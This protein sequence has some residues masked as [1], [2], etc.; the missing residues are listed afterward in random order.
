MQTPTWNRELFTQTF[1]R[2]TAETDLT[3]T[4][5][6]KL[7]GTS[8]A[9]MSRWANG[10][11]KPNHDPLRRFVDA[12]TSKF[13]KLGELGAALL[14]AAGYGEGYTPPGR[15]DDVEEIRQAAARIEDRTRRA[16]VETIIDRTLADL[17]EDR[18]RRLR[19]L[20]EVIGLAEDD[21]R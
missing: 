2:L 3:Y 17:E 14:A 5:L 12:F 6:A 1:Q 4:D 10:E 16:R 21:E 13:P 11:V 9:T 8:Q 19:A 15:P 18:V 20:R 7:G